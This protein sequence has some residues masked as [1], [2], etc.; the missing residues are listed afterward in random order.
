MNT[1]QKNVGNGNV[2]VASTNAPAIVRHEEVDVFGRPVLAVVTSD[3][4]K[5]VS[6]RHLCVAMGIAWQSQH[7]K[8]TED[9]VLGPCVTQ[10]MTQL[11]GTDQS[12]EY[13]MLP[14]SMLSG[15]L[16]K[17]N[18]KRVAPEVRPTLIKYQQE[19]CAVLDAWFRKDERAKE[20]GMSVAVKDTLDEYKDMLTRYGDALT[21]R[22]K[23][24]L[25]LSDK[26]VQLNDE[27]NDLSRENLDMQPKAAL[28]DK[29][30]DNMTKFRLG[31]VAKEADVTQEAIR[32]LLMAE[33]LMS[34]D[35][36]SNGQGRIYY[37]TEKAHD[38]GLCVFA[39]EKS[40]YKRTTRWNYFFTQKGLDYIVNHPAIVDER[41]SMQKAA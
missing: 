41:E 7:R 28:A 33:G 27:N 2:Q 17:I 20:S 8:I 9:E 15:W 21:E 16:F 38:D 3:E 13:F 5:Y 22:D 25:E 19:A 32:S 6:P 40:K 29:V 11:P 39:Y 31:V 30:T 18:P 24:V 10:M 23:K 37:A 12:R 34:W 1:S 4:G 36:R 26:I 35:D 14:M